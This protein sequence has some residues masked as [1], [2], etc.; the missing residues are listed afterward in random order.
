MKEVFDRLLTVEEVQ[1]QLIKTVTALSIPDHGQQLE[2]M[3]AQVNKIADDPSWEK[4]QAMLPHVLQKISTI[5]KEIPMRHHHHFDLR[6]K[7]FIIG[8]ITLLVTTMIAVGLLFSF[9]SENSR[10]HENDIKYRMIR[11]AVPG[12]ALWADSIYHRN[13]NEVKRQTEKLEAQEETRRKAKVI[14]KQKEKQARE[15]AQRRSNEG[16]DKE[17]ESQ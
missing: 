2:R 17:H 11:Q 14:A 12:T 3:E 5:P 6:S 1:Q 4:L 10:L 7:G 9:W 16:K 15:A 8:G 13:P